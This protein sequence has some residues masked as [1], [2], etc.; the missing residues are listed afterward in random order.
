MSTLL[1]VL[2]EAYQ[3]FNTRDLARMRPLIHPD[4][5]WPNTLEV[6]PPL[7]GKEA[8]MGHFGRV[9]ATFRPNIQTIQ[10][11]EAAADALTIDAQYLVETHDGQVW[12]D[13]RARLIYRFQDGLLSGMTIVDGF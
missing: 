3:A 5:I 2:E 12:S 11:I 8:V 6:G 10:V 1:S 7:V 13:T 4:A 9:F